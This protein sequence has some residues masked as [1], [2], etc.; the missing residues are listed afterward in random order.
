MS[1][2][3]VAVRV[4]LQPGDPISFYPATGSLRIG[5]LDSELTL[6][7]H[8]TGELSQRDAI[9]WFLSELVDLRDMLDPEQPPS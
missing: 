7:F 4:H 9:D 6:F 2:P 3:Y 5:D 8:A 1:G